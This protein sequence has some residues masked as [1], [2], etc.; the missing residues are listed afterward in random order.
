M[1]ADPLELTMPD[2]FF[3]E[4]SGAV[5]LWV[6]TESGACLGAIV[7]K[8]VLH[9][10][11]GAAA[12]GADALQTYQDHRQEID[13]VVLRRFATGSLEPVMLRETDFGKR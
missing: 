4:D 6:C 9:Y 3:H 11:F 10:R 1:C 13:A 5:R 12:D 2:A 8:E 7:R